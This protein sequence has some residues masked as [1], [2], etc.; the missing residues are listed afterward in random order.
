MGSKSKRNPHA[1]RTLQYPMSQ[2]S[3]QFP[4]QKFIDSLLDEMKD[5][6]E[7]ESIID[8]NVK[9]LDFLKECRRVLS[10]ISEIRGRPIFCYLANVVNSKIKTSIMID[11]TDDLP[12]SEMVDR[13]DTDCK[14]VDIIL[15]TP[16]GYAEQVAKFVNKLRPRFDNVGFILPYMAMS[17]GTIFCLSGD[18]IIMDSRAY[19]GPIDPQVQSKDGRYVPAQAI[20]TLVNDIQKR[21]K[22]LLDKGQQP[23][24]TDIQLLN[25]IDAKELGNAISASNYSI[26]LVTN[27][28]ANYKFKNWTHHRSTTG[29]PVSEEDKNNRAKEIAAQLCDHSLWKTHSRGITREM[30]HSECRLEILHP[31]DITNLHRAIRRFWALM[32]WAFEKTN[33]YKAFIS[34]NYGLFRTETVL[35]IING[36]GAVNG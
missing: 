10:E 16:G 18:E 4:Q 36:G 1:Q 6:H 35:N 5:G 25:R 3:G 27:Y 28:L 32:Y 12:F 21:G 29:L 8:K 23:N 30:A 31:E 33:V 11:T 17:A 2:Q 26:E 24:W 19:I 9:N 34:D 22:E 15:V 7:Y 20:T 13:I 14:S